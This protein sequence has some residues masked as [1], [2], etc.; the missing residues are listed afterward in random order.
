MP[1]LNINGNILSDTEANW[2]V[3]ATVYTNKQILVSTDAQYTGTDQN[4]FKIANGTDT[5]ANLDYFADTAST[6]K[7]GQGE[8][9]TQAEVDAGTDTTR[10][11]TPETLANYS[12][13]GGTNTVFVQYISVTNTA[14]ADD[15]DYF[16]GVGTTIGNNA[17][18]L[19]QVELPTSTLK[20][21]YITTYNGSTV[22]S[23]ETGTFYIYHND[24]ANNNTI[25]SSITFDGNRSVG[26]AVTGLSIA[27][28]GGLSWIQFRTPTFATNP[29][30]ARVVVILE[31]EL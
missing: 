10:W 20:S 14:L 11:V 8:I 19:V 2:T 22:G 21:A 9:A 18:Q 23:S 6:T 4:K 1:T 30:A 26:F 29:N 12:G 13:L 16:V 25:S 15:T 3:D 7:I 31:L 5:W 17:N 28:T 27:I 24:G